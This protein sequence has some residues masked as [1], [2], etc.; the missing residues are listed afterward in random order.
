MKL[1][2]AEIKHKDYAP[3]AWYFIKRFQIYE[4]DMNWMMR[5][6]S[7]G[8]GTHTPWGA[9]CEWIKANYR[10]SRIMGSTGALPSCVQDPKKKAEARDPVSGAG[11]PVFTLNS[12]GEGECKLMPD[13]PKYRIERCNTL[14]S[15]N[16]NWLTSFIYKHIPEPLTP[17]ASQPIG[18]R[19]PPLRFDSQIVLVD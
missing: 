16:R 4:G 10:Q 6:T 13:F 18:Y 8:G 17:L 11:L 3:E 12:Q 9:A 7:E 15:D 1:A 5:Q 14:A 2:M 19:P